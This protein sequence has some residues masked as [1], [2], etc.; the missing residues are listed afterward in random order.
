MEIVKQRL[1]NLAVAISLA[2]P[3][4]ATSTGQAADEAAVGAGAAPPATAAADG[5]SGPRIEGSQINGRWREGSRLVDQLGHFKSVGDR[6][7]FS[8]TDGKLHFDCLENLGSERIGRT[9]SDNPDQLEWSVCGVLTECHGT[10]YLLVTQA[11]LK[12][13]AA[14]T[15]R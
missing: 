3:F 15:R 12:T 4:I 14:R 6:V 1:A 10:N 13:K 8:S 7:T 2:L 11:M 5:Q 9:I